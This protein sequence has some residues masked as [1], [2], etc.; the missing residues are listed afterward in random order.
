MLP[1]THHCLLSTCALNRIHVGSERL[2][3]NKGTIE[4]NT[5]DGHPEVKEELHVH[6]FSYIVRKPPA[7]TQDTHSYQ[8][9]FQILPWY[10]PG[11]YIYLTALC[12]TVTCWV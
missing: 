1:G 10:L 5:P 3:E 9:S 11:E 12:I 8:T 6:R 4:H 2:S 7:W